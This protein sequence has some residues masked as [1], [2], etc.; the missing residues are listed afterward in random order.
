MANIKLEKQVSE[1]I[2]SLKAYEVENYDCEIKLHANENPFSLPDELT[3]GLQKCFEKLKLNRYP[4]PDTRTLKKAITGIVN[5]PPE[6]LVVGNGSDELIQLILQVFCKSGDSIA[7]PDPT[8][9]MYSIIGRGLGLIPQSFPLD[10]NWDFD[11]EEFL[12]FLEDK[13]VR[14]VFLS[15]PNNPTG[16]CYTKGEIDKII[17]GFQGIVVLDE[18]YFDFAQQTFCQDI[19]TNNN[20]IVL[21]SLSKIGL[22]SLRVGYGL[23]DPYIIDQI[24]KVRLPYNSNTISQEC[25]AHVLQNFSPIRDQ[26]KLILRE[27]DRLLKELSKFEFLTVFPSDSNFILFRVATDADKLFKGLIENG[28][29]IRNLNAHPRL[30]NCLRVTVGTEKENDIFLAQ[31]GKIDR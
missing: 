25:S 10:K 19:K 1:N 7:F 16:N 22:A 31:L 11:G 8:F 4:D 30:K 12:K 9:G 18:A 14:V 28:I 24:N 29:L 2:K 3:P 20:L 27:R 15:Y 21:R 6:S 5:I 23:A 13:N 17:A 26:I